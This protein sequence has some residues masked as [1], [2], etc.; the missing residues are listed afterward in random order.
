MN[1]RTVRT[2]RSTNKIATGNPAITLKRQTTFGD[3]GDAMSQPMKYLSVGS[4]MMLCCLYVLVRVSY[5]SV[6]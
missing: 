1:Y 3:T 2:S 6:G 4:V 5:R